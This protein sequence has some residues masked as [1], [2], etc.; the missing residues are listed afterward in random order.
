MLALPALWWVN[1][2][3]GAAGPKVATAGVDVAAEANTTPAPVTVEVI[4]STTVGRSN[5]PPADTTSSGAP[6]FLDGPQGNIGG[7]SE[8]AVPARPTTDV[9][10]VDATY[11]S[12]IV[13]TRKCLAIGI[14]SGR[15]ITVINVENKRTTTCVVTFAPATQRESLVL[16]TDQFLELAD[17]SDAPIPVEIRQ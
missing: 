6:V 5:L 3:E 14:N 12:T 7:A 8:I 16:Q 15:T 4:V 1:R 17:L 11:S 9:L 13:G 2:D 10:L